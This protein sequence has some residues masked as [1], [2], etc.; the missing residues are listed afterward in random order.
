MNVT[1][2]NKLKYNHNY[3]TKTEQTLTNH[4]KHNGNY[5]MFT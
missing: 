2:E 4:I 1:G 5:N 3:K